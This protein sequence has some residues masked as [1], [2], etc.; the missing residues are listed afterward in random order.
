[1][2]TLIPEKAMKSPSRLRV[3]IGPICRPG[4]I[5]SL[6]LVAAAGLRAA[7]DFL[8]NAFDSETEASQWARWWGSALQTYEWD[9]SVDADGNASSGSLKVT[10]QFN[11]ATY[12]GDNQFAALRNF[13]SLD[14][15]QYTNLVMDILWDHGPSTVQMVVEHLPFDRPLTYTTVQTVLNV[16]HRKRSVRRKLRDRAY[17]YEAAVSRTRAA[18][19]ALEDFVRRLF[20][21]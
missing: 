1:M 18:S 10:V 20:R 14:G 8:I 16:L 3:I 12:G 17:R 7:D 9:A 5:V 13:T 6:C 11:L 4:L 19:T 21:G 2:Q 15:S